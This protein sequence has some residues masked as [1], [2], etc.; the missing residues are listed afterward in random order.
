MLMAGSQPL[1]QRD[2]LDEI[3]MTPFAASSCRYHAKLGTMHHSLSAQIEAIVAG[4]DPASAGGFHSHTRWSHVRESLK[5]SSTCF[6]RRIQ[7]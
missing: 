2:S 6:A 3:H 5:P 4:T 7:S 1:A